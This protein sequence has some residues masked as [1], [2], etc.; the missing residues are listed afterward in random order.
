[1]SKSLVLAAL[2]GSV[3]C[4]TSP[5]PAPTPGA[6]A[7]TPGQAS[8][9]TAAAGA[10]AQADTTPI[11]CPEKAGIC[12]EVTPD[13]AELEVNGDKLGVVG[14]LAVGGVVFVS[15]EP[16]IHLVTLRRDGYVTWRSEVTVGPVAETMA[17]TLEQAE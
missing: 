12:F 3:A 6:P 1:M 2:I 13:D 5:T 16:G 11:G 4:A 10:E 15:L 17:V 7:P 14:A 9:D 8:A